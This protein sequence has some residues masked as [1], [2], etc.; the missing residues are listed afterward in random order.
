MRANLVRQTSNAVNSVNHQLKN[1]RFLFLVLINSFPSN[2]DK[3]FIA[4]NIT[5]ARI[6]LAEVI[7]LAPKIKIDF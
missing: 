1:H 7:L 6:I 2:S 3:E 4:K 5:S